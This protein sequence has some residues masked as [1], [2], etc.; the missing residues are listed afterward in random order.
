VRDVEKG[1]RLVE[2]ERGAALGEARGRTL[3]LAAQRVD[4]SGRER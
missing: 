2:D 1:G 4:A 3:P